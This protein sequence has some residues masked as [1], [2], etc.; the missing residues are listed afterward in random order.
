MQPTLSSHVEIRWQSDLYKLINVVWS[1]G[2]QERCFIL[3]TAKI[4]REIDEFNVL[5]WKGT[6]RSVS[7]V[8]W[9]TQGRSDLSFNTNLNWL[10]DDYWFC[11][12]DIIPRYLYVHREINIFH[13]FTLL[14]ATRGVWFSCREHRS[15]QISL[16]DIWN[17][18][19]AKDCRQEKTESILN[20]DNSCP[21]GTHELRDK[22]SCLRSLQSLSWS[23][24][25]PTFM[26]SKDSLSYSENPTQSSKLPEPVKSWPYSHAS[27]KIHF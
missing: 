22:R 14:M 26:E 21:L 4:S 10:L 6:V 8:K 20:C 11:H 12:Q 27:F 15:R 17:L 13:V 19:H 1:S 9:I 18:V 24:N 3:A 5:L 2:H 23:Q 16:N 25:F 7:L